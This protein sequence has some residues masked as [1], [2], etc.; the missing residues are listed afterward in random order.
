MPLRLPWPTAAPEPDFSGIK[1]A[2]KRCTQKNPKKAFVDLSE[3][4]VFSH[5]NKPVFAELST[6]LTQITYD[7]MLDN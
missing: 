4:I 5:N 7:A 6:L 3:F 1:T 2:R